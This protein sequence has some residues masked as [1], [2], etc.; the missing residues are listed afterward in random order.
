M[1]EYKF[2]GSSALKSN[3]KS[4]IFLLK[5]SMLDHFTGGML[6]YTGETPG[7]SVLFYQQTQRKWVVL[8]R[9]HLQCSN[10]YQSKADIGIFT[11]QD[12][13]C[14]HVVVTQ[15]RN[16][17]SRFN[18]EIKKHNYSFFFSIAIGKHD[19]LRNKSNAFFR[20]QADCPWIA[21]K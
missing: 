20:L 18:S 5:L 13:Y 14:T 9:L 4:Q 21:S 6:I 16:V 3:I 2:T 7:L 8:L 19:I 12:K 1:V 17:L 15:H 11:L 10:G